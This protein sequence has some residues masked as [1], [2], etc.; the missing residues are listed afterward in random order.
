MKKQARPTIQ[1]TGF[2]NW[3]WKDFAEPEHL[4]N[5]RT[6]IKEASI[7]IADIERA[8]VTQRM[9]LT[10]KLRRLGYIEEPGEIAI[11]VIPKPALSTIRKEPEFESEPNIPLD[12][13]KLIGLLQSWDGRGGQKL[14]NRWLA[15][16]KVTYQHED[17]FIA[18]IHFADKNNL[19]PTARKIDLILVPS[20]KHWGIHRISTSGDV[21]FNKWAKSKQPDGMLPEGIEYS[22]GD[23]MLLDTRGRKPKEVSADTET[24]VFA[25]CGIP[26]IPLGYRTNNLWKIYLESKTDIGKEDTEEEDIPN[27]LNELVYEMAS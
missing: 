14:R 10:G 12:A 18:T 11:L 22:I 9:A 8:K 23:Q 19:K 20:K 2:T 25:L 6:T 7:L 5:L 16:E 4:Q 1:E 13:N 21:E 27:K 24:K 15:V 17:P 3:N 26:F